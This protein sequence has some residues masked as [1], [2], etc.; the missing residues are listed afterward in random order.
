MVRGIYTG[1]AG[2]IAEMHR[3]D[4]VSNNLANVDKPAYKYD[5]AIFKA[6]PEMLI[7]RMNDDGVVKLPIGSYD[8]APIVGK[9][10]TGV[11]MNESFTRFEQ[12]ALKQ[13][14]NKFDLA[15]DGQGFFV[16]DTPAGERYTRNGS[17]LMDREGYLVT[18]DGYKVLGQEGHI[19]IKDFNFLVDKEGHIIVN[20]DEQDDLERLTNDDQNEWRRPEVLDQLRIVNFE[21][22]RYLD[23]Q[24]DS[25]FKETKYSGP[26]VEVAE[27]RPKIE[28]G[29]L[30]ASNVNAVAE[31][32]R[33]IEVQRSYEASHKAIQSHDQLLQRLVNEVARM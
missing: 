13:T 30:E 33:M 2:M 4:V 21:N 25:F 9:I 12:G 3:M 31:M 11:E 23:K 6:F 29:F 1:A 24:G 17:F 22:L 15:L 28:Q 14:D 19:H 5:T 32:V 18:K 20:M 10:G 16:L 26:A 7:S 27:G 8:V